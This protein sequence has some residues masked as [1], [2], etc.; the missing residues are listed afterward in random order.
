MGNQL[1]RLMGRHY[2]MIELFLQELS[3]K[4]IAERLNCTSQCVSLVFNS[5]IVQQQLARRRADMEKS[6]NQANS[7]TLMDA[8]HNLEQ[9]SVDA[10]NVHIDL[11]RSGDESVQQRSANAILDRVGIGTQ[12]QADKGQ[13]IVIEADTVNLLSIAAGECLSVPKEKVLEHVG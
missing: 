4:E 2:M 5:A 1:K 3:H 10:A 7:V 11:L 13:A 6:S 8:R 12:T 9:A